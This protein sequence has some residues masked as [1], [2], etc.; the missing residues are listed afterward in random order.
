MSKHT[1]GPWSISKIGN[2]YDQF[3]IFA[4]DELIVNAITGKANADLIVSVP[5]LLEAIRK[6]V[7]SLEDFADENGEYKPTPEGLLSV[8]KDLDKAIAKATIN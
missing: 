2:D 8:V 7:I 1:P 3:M 6:A 4:G 5:E